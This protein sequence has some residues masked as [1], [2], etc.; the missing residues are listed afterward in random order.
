MRVEGQVTSSSAMMVISV[1]TFGS[2]S[3]TCNRLLAIPVY[4]TRTFGVDRVFASFSKAKNLSAV[5]TR[6][7]S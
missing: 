3:Q 5:V 6:I 4:S 1:F 7:S 2:A